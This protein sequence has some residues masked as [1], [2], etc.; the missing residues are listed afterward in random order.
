VITCSCRLRPSACAMLSS[1]SPVLAA[2]LWCCYPWLSISM[3]ML[4]QLSPWP[5]FSPW[6]SPASSPPGPGSGFTARTVLVTVYQLNICI[7]CYS[8]LCLL[9]SIALAAGT[10]CVLLCM[11]AE[12]Y[13]HGLYFLVGGVKFLD[14]LFPGFLVLAFNH[15]PRFLA[16]LKR[17]L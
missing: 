7:L 17:F 14:W 11:L 12:L 16:R 6:H 13:K 10:M 3:V 4:G 15:D 9:I 2:V 5:A 8:S 1:S